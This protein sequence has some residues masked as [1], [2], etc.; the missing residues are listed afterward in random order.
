MTDKHAGIR[1][2][3]RWT[4]AL[5]AG[6]VAFLVLLWLSR[7]ASFSWLPHAES[8]RWVVDAGF[9]AVGAGVVAT[10]AGWWA[11]REQE[12]TPE[13]GARV[14]QHARASGH[15]RITQV[16]GDLHNGGRSPDAR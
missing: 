7:L 12:T 3:A 6:L 8:D 10:A 9:A 14:E 2:W 16:G 5:V 11:G 1:P 13:P 4:V 15:A